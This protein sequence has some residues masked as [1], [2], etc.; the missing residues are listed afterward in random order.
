MS[1]MIEKIQTK[2][3]EISREYDTRTHYSQ[4][5]I[6]NVDQDHCRLTGSVLDEALL[7]EI[8]HKLSRTFSN[9]TF[10]IESVQTL[11]PGRQVTVLTSVTGLYAGP[12]FSDEMLSQLLNGWCLE[13]LIEK[14]SWVF[15]RQPDGYLGWTYRSY[16]IQDPPPEPNHLVYK[17]I[18]R[19]RTHA[20]YGSPLSGRVAGGTAVRVVQTEGK[21]SLLLL[22][23]GKQG[24]VPA[25]DLRPLEQLPGDESDRRS[26]IVSV[27]KTFTGVPYLWGGVTAYGLDCSGYVQLLHRLVGVTIPRD[28]DFQFAGGQP[29]E[30]P[31][32]SGDLLF[33]SSQGGHRAIT[34]VGMSLGD[35]RII[36]SS[37]ARNGVHIDN[38][39]T[40][41]WLDDAFVGA[42]TYVNL[43]AG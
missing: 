37:R 8:I 16:L 20:G 24:W 32:K 21:W 6:V 28:A 25:K 3:N 22:A 14:D 35:W 2:L 29:I 33:F 9:M 12:S 13:V 18:S 39:K 7:G 30:P 5:T 1:A 11:R 31:F 26:Q 40:V 4:I 19:L 15:V 36:H 10:E 17:S 42:C 43:P 34:H 38:V 23:G 27:A 41:S